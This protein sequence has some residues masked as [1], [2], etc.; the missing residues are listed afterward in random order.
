[1]PALPLDPY[2]LLVVNVVNLLVLA[3]LLPVIMGRRLSPA[4]RDARRSLIVQAVAWT[5]IILAKQHVPP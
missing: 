1:M 2:T 5:A 4:A 3:V